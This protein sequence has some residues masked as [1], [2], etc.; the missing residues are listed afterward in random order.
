M[1]FIYQIA[2]SIVDRRTAQK[3]AESKKF[4]EI[5]LQWKAKKSFIKEVFIKK[6]IKEKIEEFKNTT[7][8]KYSVGE[9]VLTNWFNGGNHWWGSIQSYQS[10]T[11]YKGPIV[12]KIENVSVDTNLLEEVLDNFLDNGKFDNLMLIEDHYADF[13]E[14]VKREEKSRIQKILSGT[15][16]PTTP[17]ITWVYKIRVVKDE[18]E[19]WRYSWPEDFFLKLD[20]AACLLSQKAWKKDLKAKKNSE[21]AAEARKEL[22]V[23]LN[24]LRK[25]RC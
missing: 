15:D 13:C 22:D 2:K 25:Q 11:P 5:D 12:V 24:E 6:F 7:A 17:T 9:K 18:A 14:I 23:L 20:S 19:Y 3:E 21:K 4:V 16:R 10:H 1:D 8:P